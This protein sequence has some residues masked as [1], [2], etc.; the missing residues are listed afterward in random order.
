MHCLEREVAEGSCSGHWCGVARRAIAKDLLAAKG[1]GRPQSPACD[2]PAAAEPVETGAAEAEESCK[3]L[4]YDTPPHLCREKEEKR[5]T[6]VRQVV[7]ELLSGSIAEALEVPGLPRVP[8]DVEAS[9]TS[10]GKLAK[11]TRRS[12]GAE[13]A[14]ETP[15]GMSP[16]RALAPAPLAGMASA[17]ESHHLGDIVILGAG[18][19]QEFRSRQAVITHVGETQCM[20]AILDDSGRFGLGKCLAMLADVQPRSRYL[21]LGS[22]VVVRGLTGD[23]T[24]RLNGCT[25]IISLHPQQG[26]PI[27][28][29][30]KSTLEMPQLA[31][32]VRL[33]DPPPG[34]QG[35]VLLEP[36]FL[37][38][39]R[40][41]TL[42]AAPEEQPRH[43]TP[44]GLSGR[45]STSTCSS[46]G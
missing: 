30:S 6:V 46:S 1:V 10:P 23:K 34:A 28:I 15:K 9:A 29:P 5:Q 40:T 37:V 35:P 22:Q 17:A 11:H 19:P 14:P 25:G 2:P 16:Q 20:V 36:R 32:C 44:R 3:V 43:R 18:V 42:L 31:V 45:N 27:L 24:S 41:A 39:H 26:H 21:R 13:P 7:R 12:D 8:T 33:L 4:E 38:Q